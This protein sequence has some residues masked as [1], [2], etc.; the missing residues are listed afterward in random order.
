VRVS[1]IIICIAALSWITANSQD[2]QKID[3]DD[4]AELTNLSYDT[5]YVI[6]FWATWCS[7]CVK[8][9]PVFEKLHKEH[10]DSK[11]KVILVSLDFPGQIDSRVKPFLAEKGISA[12]VKIMTDMDYNA[13]IDRVDPSWT[14]AIP[15]TLIYKKDKRAFLEKEITYDELVKHIYQ[16]QN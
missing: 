5:T 10:V 7:P 16:I 11:V 1:L 4:V 2:I 8:E 14:G 15:A 12:E 6:N 3:G 9:I 13:W